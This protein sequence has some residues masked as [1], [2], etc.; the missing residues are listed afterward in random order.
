MKR[1]LSVSILIS[2][3]GLGI[4]G[5]VF[6]VQAATEG[7]L[8]GCFLTEEAA[9][10]TDCPQS[11]TEFCGFASS[12]C[13][14]CCLLQTL[15]NVTDWIFVIL[16]GVA[17]IFVIIGA[18]NLL[19]SAGDTTKVSSGRNYIMYAAIGLIVGFLA[20]AIPAIV[21]LVVGQ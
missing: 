7:V 17:S 15:Y 11:A 18:M 16:V 1:I 10:L 5:P 6:A 4:L 9:R 8:K 21:K 12:T 3:I 19:M 20:K 14:V 2:L 13:G